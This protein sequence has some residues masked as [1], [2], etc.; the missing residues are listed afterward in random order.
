MHGRGVE[1]WAFR[2]KARDLITC[3]D[4]LERGHPLVGEDTEGYL[5]K[6]KVALAGH[7]GVHEGEAPD[8]FRTHD[9]LAV[10]PAEYDERLRCSF[11]DA[12]GERQ[13]RNLLLED[14]REAH[15]L[16][17]MVEDALNAM[18][19]EVAHLTLG[20]QHVLNEC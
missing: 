1:I 9:T 4:T 3:V 20:G 10:G 14:A 19:Q 7:D 11:L 6:N 8:D 18:I 17:L 12:L 16:G 5:G 15:E 2:R 13:G